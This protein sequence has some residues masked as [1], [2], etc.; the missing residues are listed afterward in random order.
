MIAHPYHL[1]FIHVPKCAGM[2]VEEAL[3]GLPRGQRNEQHA[4]ASEL[5]ERYPEEWEAYHRFAIVRHPVARCRSFTA[6]YRRFDPLWRRHLG[7]IEDELLLRDLLFSSN[8]LTR[9]SA[10]RMLSGDEEILKFEELNQAWPVFAAEHGLPRVLP[11]RNRSPSSPPPMSPVVPHLVAAIFPEDFDRFGYPRPE[12]AEELSLADRG[13]LCWAELH[14]WAV[15][16]P[17][18]W[19]VDAARAAEA[20][21]ADWRARLPDPGWI[22]RYD[23]LVTARPPDLTGD[24][25]VKVWVEELHED[26]NRAL[27]K[28]LWQPWQA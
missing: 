24:Q 20:W 12:R 7:E 1:I 5:S 11:Q 13:T 21:L 26:V 3:G 23:D 19:S 25:A 18:R 22:A 6:F 10:H 15:R 28:R 17:A 2:S 4:T 14:A 27:G 8:M 16:L 9:F